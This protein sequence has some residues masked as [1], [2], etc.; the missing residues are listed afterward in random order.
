M[1]RPTLD[2]M[3]K[4]AELAWP[5]GSELVCAI[6][7]NADMRPQLVRFAGLV[8]ADERK[9]ALEAILEPLPPVASDNIVASDLELILRRA[10]NRVRCMP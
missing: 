2:E 7:E 4:E 6:N 9:R 10:W 8:R 5:L 3:A 1:K